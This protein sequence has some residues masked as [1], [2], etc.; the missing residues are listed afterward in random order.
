M[1]LGDI[2]YACNFIKFYAIWFR[3]VEA[4][5]TLRD[6]HPSTFVL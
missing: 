6:V 1:V 3:I 5:K 2:D 4:Y